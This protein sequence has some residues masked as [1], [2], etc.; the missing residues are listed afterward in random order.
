MRPTPMLRI[1]TANRLQPLARCEGAGSDRST[2]SQGVSLSVRR[3]LR[4]TLSSLE[5]CRPKNEC[6]SFPSALGSRQEVVN[7]LRSGGCRQGKRVLEQ[8]AIS[9]APLFRGSRD[10]RIQRVRV[11]A[12]GLQ[13]CHDSS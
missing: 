8:R 7:H 3:T 4:L 12:L 9:G 13:P 5:V 6:P 1:F 11:D 10:V 2:N